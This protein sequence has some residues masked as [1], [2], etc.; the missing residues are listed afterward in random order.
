MITAMVCKGL[1]FSVNVA[2]VPTH[3]FQ[4]GSIPTRTPGRGRRLLLKV[5]R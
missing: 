3:G 5:G 1:G 2:F 4:T